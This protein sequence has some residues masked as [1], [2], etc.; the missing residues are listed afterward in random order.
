MSRTHH[1]TQRERDEN[2]R[3]TRRRA[4]TRLTKLGKLKGFAFYFGNTDRPQNAGN[5][6]GV[7]FNAGQRRRNE[8]RVEK[9]IG[10]RLE[11]RRLK[12]SLIP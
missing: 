3:A 1:L 5:N 8:A 11:R 9:V 10:R 7:G 6:Y 12:R 4:K 2:S